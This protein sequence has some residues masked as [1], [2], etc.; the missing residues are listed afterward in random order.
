L[1]DNASFK[2]SV[3]CPAKAGH[4]VTTVLLLEP[5]QSQIDDPVVTGSPG[6]AGR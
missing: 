4:P 1:T 3:P 6:R 5:M 2:L